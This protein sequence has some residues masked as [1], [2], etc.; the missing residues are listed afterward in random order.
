MLLN[1][2]K[3]RA[4]R[5]TK[6]PRKRHITSG[7]MMGDEMSTKYV[8]VCLSCLALVHLP[9]AGWGGS[10]PGTRQEGGLLIQGGG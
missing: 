1:V 2:A 3:L 5:V 9:A 4:T 6:G 7:V 10:N 8:R